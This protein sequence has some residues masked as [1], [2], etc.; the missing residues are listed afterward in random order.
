MN[1][2][3]TISRKDVNS[4]T[5]PAYTN[6]SLTLDWIVVFGYL[7]LT[8]W[9]GMLSGK[10]SRIRDFFLAGRSLPPASRFRARS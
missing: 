6:T 1:G 3:Y 7:G 8:T 10:Q 5:Q 9:V 2:F 4:M